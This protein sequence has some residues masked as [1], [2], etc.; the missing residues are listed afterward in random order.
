[1]RYTHASRR[2]LLPALVVLLAACWLGGGVTADPTWID[3]SLQLLALPVLLL[4]VASLASAD[5]ESQGQLVYLGIATGLVI[6]LVPALQLLPLPEALWSAPQARQAMATDLSQAGVT[7]HATRWALSPFGTEGSLWAMLPALAAFLA[8]LAVPAR[9]RRRV[10]QAVVLLVLFN[11]VFAFFEAGLPRESSL[12]LYRTA[13]FGG[14]LINSNHQATACII[15]AAL[16]IG[17]AVEARIRAGHGETRPHLQWWYAALACFFL[18]VVPLSTSRAGWAIALPAVAAA[19]VLTG[20]LPLGKIGRSKRVTVVAL[21]LVVLAIVG[22]RAGMGWMAVDEAEELRHALTSAAVDMGKAHAPLGSGVGAF[23][24]AF[25]QDAPSRL[26]LANYVNHAHNEYAQ[27]WLTTG[28]PGMLALGCLLAVMCVAGWQLL[29]VRGKGSNAVLA[30]A[31]FVAICAVLVHSWVDYPLRTTT[32]MA[33]VA[34]LAGLML[35]ALSDAGR[36]E[37]AG[38]RRISREDE[39][40]PGSA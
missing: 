2:L 39:V 1:M 25:E 18:L 20:G 36:R 32:L 38:R 24:E 35:A 3:E 40:T 31:C 14:L 26:L 9:Y 7:S 17:L 37:K 13:G 29:R 34:A 6:F 27:W 10:V 30:A 28:W 22:L 15:G 33:T 16:A 12:R 8:A 11:I 5:H 23:V 4:A 21:V 19:L